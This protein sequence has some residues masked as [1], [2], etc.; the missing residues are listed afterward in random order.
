M[1]IRIVRMSFKKEERQNF[2]AVFDAS[3]NKIRAFRGCQ[4]LSLH[5]DHHDENVFYTLSHWNTQED[6]DSYRASAL[7]KDTWARTKVLF[8][9]KPQA[10]SLE[11]MDELI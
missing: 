2:L 5:Q 11:K 4:Y 1:I 6:L 9:D 7:F 10:F 3:K 8:A